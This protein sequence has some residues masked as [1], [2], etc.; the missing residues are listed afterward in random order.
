MSPGF[1]LEQSLETSTKHH[2]YLLVNIIYAKPEKSNI[3]F[4]AAAGSDT[5]LA[6]FS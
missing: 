4:A 5:R 6:I 1:E 3:T 2:A